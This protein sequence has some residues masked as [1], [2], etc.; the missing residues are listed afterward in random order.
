MNTSEF[1]A[2]LWRR[3]DAIRGALKVRRHDV[4]HDFENKPDPNAWCLM[5]P[6]IEV[7][8]ADVTVALRIPEPHTQLVH[9]EVLG[10]TLALGVLKSGQNPDKA[11]LLRFFR[12]AIR[13]PVPVSGTCSHHFEGPF[14]VV[15]V[16]RE[17]HDES[18][19]T[20]RGAIRSLKHG[21][22]LRPE[23]LDDSRKTTAGRLRSQA[24]R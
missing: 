21:K 14:L 8:D 19:V 13:L 16:R 1:L 24:A 18:N 6:C 20:R 7:G 3:T 22:S 9:T 10:Q 12:R 4:L 2:R 5:T 11:P 17:P 23:H 15:A